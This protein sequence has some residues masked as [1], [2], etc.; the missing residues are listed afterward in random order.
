ME[1]TSYLRVNFI[2]QNEYF[3]INES[4]SNLSQI[5]ETKNIIYG[6]INI[7]LSNNPRIPIS[8]HT[9]IASLILDYPK[10]EKLH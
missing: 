3:K 7:G 4:K 9:C 2:D 1:S 8:L 6:S 5:S 10:K